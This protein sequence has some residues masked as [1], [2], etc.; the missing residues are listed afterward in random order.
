MVNPPHS[1]L[2]KEGYL[3][4]NY[5]L[6]EEEGVVLEASNVWLERYYQPPLDLG[7][8]LGLSS[9]LSFFCTIPTSDLL[10]N[11]GLYSISQWLIIKI[12][13]PSLV[14]VRHFSNTSVY[15]S[16]VVLKVLSIE[17]PLIPPV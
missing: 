1:L 2:E 13:V 16:P 4:L 3:T 11:L 10:K 8:S 9:D 7:E 6:A 17:T 14:L 12:R 5:S 15:L